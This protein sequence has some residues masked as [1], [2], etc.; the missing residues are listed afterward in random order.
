MG[1]FDKLSSIFKGISPSSTPAA[2]APVVTDSEVEATFKVTVTG[3]SGPT[4]P[5]ASDEVAE[6]M[7]RYRFV[8]DNQ[9]PAL[10]PA[11][12]WWDEATHKRRLREGSEKVFSWLE[13]FVSVELA[14]ALD[15]KAAK[16]E[17]GPLQSEALAKEL[18]AIVRERRKLKQPHEDVLRALYG[19]C[20]MCDLVEALKFKGH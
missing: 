13:P 19:A 14:Q 7:A 12:R 11:D 15:L 18:R 3:P 16:T 9:Q 5:V 17:W 2:P 6:A 4:V 20:V 1:L 10:Q 8:F